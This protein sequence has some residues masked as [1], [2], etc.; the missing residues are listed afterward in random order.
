M[1]QRT[2]CVF[3]LLLAL[4]LATGA[5]AAIVKEKVL[6][7][8]WYGGGIDSNV[9]NL[10]ANANFPDNP[11]ETRL[12]D[13]MDLPDQ[14]ADYFGARLRAW[15]TPPQSGDYTFWTASDDDSE[16]WLSTDDTAA[17]AK[18]ICN[19]EGWMGYQDWTYTSGAPG[20]TYKSALITLEAGKRYYIEALLGDGTGGG[21]VSVAWA[22]PGI[23]DAPTVIAGTYLECEPSEALY[24]SKSPNPANGAEDIVAPL[25]QWTAGIYAL[26]DN[27]YF[28]TDPN[29]GAAQLMGTQ[30]SVISLFFYPLPLEPGVTYYWR[31]DTTDTAGPQHVGKVWSFTV[32]PVK[33]TEPSPADGASWMVT[34]Q[35]LGWKAGQNM[36]THDLYF[37]T[38]ANAVAAGDASTFKG[39]LADATFDTGDLEP[40]TTYY[41]RVDEI[42]M[43]GSKFVGDVWSF[44]TTLPV[45]ALPSVRSGRTSAA[46]PSAICSTTRTSRATRPLRTWWLRSRQ[47]TLPTITA[48]VCPRGCMCRS[49]AS[50][51]S[52]SPAT[53]PRTCS[54][55]PTRARRSR[56]P[57]SRV[58]P[59][60]MPMI[61]SRSRS[62]RRS[63]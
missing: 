23:G 12:L 46:Q 38:D 30:P 49:R 27:V 40:S 14:P 4:V 60:T 36:P 45:S 15:L 5:S 52:G 25:F 29:L 48:G 17:N 7:D 13:A 2:M 62:R 11:A 19:V 10:K 43:M 56:L 18:M 35:T 26:M 6:C 9:D 37:G 33:A 44:T 20:T 58:G 22:G 39:N 51:P 34:K 21:F 47:M 28:G 50:T 61:Q 31:I 24:L 55:V 57:K 63:P 1:S 8:L 53:T 3:A 54:W 42:D 59:G 16:V 41:W 32:M